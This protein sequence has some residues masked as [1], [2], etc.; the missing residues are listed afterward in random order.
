MQAPTPEQQLLAA[1]DSALAGTFDFGIRVLKPPRWQPAV[2]SEASRELAN[3]PYR[4]DGN[5]WHEDTAR[6]TYMAANVLMTGVLDNLG[7][8]RSLIGEPM[9]AIGPRVLARSAMEIGATAWWLMEPGIGVRRRTCRQLVLS[10]ISARRSAQVAEELGDPDGITDA[11]DREKEVA[12]LIKDL[13]I[14][15]PNGKRFSPAIEDEKLPEATGLTAAMLKPCYPG[16]AE[17]RAFYRTY[18]AVLHGH[19][20][21]LMNYMTPTV[22]PDEQNLLSWQLR[23]SDLYRD[24]EL[25]LLSFREPFKR[26]NQHM[27]WGRIEYDLWHAKTGKFLNW[28][29]RRNLQTHPLPSAC[30]AACDAGLRRHQ[31]HAAALVG[32]PCPASGTKALSEHNLGAFRPDFQ[33]PGPLAGSPKRYSPGTGVIATLRQRLLNRITGVGYWVAVRARSRTPAV[34]P[35]YMSSVVR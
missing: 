8:I 14:L 29:T 30:A 20:Y 11:H 18:S 21:G 35:T 4:Q 17:T 5:P 7:S 23:G 12:D 3:L 15:P 28:V 24:V 16:H 19:L 25:A 32:L 2:D 26:I 27:N 13:A 33:V 31:R 22:Q 1:L 34:V 9:P 10:L 6:S